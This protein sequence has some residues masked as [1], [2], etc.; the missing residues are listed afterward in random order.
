MGECDPKNCRGGSP[1]LDGNVRVKAKHKSPKD[2]RKWCGAKCP[3][4][5][6]CSRGK[7]HQGEHEAHYEHEGQD[8]ACARWYDELGNTNSSKHKEVSKRT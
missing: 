5:F 7:G 3:A 2:W 4:G 6:Q 1:C 8:V